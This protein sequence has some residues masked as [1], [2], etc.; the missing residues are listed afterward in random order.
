M[1]QKIRLAHLVERRLERLDQLGRQ[2]TDKP[3]GIGQQERQVI[4]NHLANSRIECREQLILGKDI[5][6]AQ[7][8]HEGRLSDVRIAYQRHTD[9]LSAVL[10]LDALL[11]VDIHQLTFQSR[12]LVE[13]DS[14]IGLQL[15]LTRTTH[16][17]TTTLALQVCPQ[18]GQAGQHITIL[19]QLHLRLG[20]RRLRPTGEDVENQVG[21]VE[22]LDLK[23]L[24]DVTQLLGRQ[25]IVEDHQ[26]DLVL[27]DI[28]FDLLQFAGTDE[29]HRIGSLRLLRESFYR[30]DTS[31]IR[32]EGQLV[33][34][35][36]HF[37]LI[38][39]GCHQAH[40]NRSLGLCL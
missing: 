35:F 9:H 40:Q 32:Q 2:L 11:L 27:L 39:L 26:A 15:R 30:L 24:L 23:L 10:P 20:V 7:Q 37:L 16:T 18:A 13:D 29:G 4:D 38:L 28:S 14:L 36:L 8:V 17:D 1:H 12:D 22:D 19:R 34:I 3:D 21:P 33:E 31:R 25:L 6:F 5:T